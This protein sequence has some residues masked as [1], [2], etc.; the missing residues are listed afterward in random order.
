MKYSSKTVCI[1]IK[2]AN[3]Q[4]LKFVIPF[5][6]LPSQVHCSSPSLHQNTSLKWLTPSFFNM[7]SWR[8]PGRAKMQCMLTK[9]I[10]KYTTGFEFNFQLVSIFVECWSN[11]QNNFSIH[12][13][14]HQPSPFLFLSLLLAMC[15]YPVLEL[16]QGHWTSTS[17]SSLHLW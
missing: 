11:Q 16:N 8:H 3:E 14:I 9:M 6:F 1:H 15:H 5:F 13:P 10:H 17:T 7:H 4:T 12:P 2:W